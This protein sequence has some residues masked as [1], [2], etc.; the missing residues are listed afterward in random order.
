MLILRLQRLH[1]NLL[2]QE[3]EKMQPIEACALLFGKLSYG[4]LL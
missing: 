3:A 4:K 2:K 1:V